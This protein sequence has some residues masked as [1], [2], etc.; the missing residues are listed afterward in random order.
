M[1]E[2]SPLIVPMTVEAFVVNDQVRGGTF[3]RAQMQYNPMILQ[4]TSAQPGIGD[5]DTNFTQPGT[6][7][8]NYY[9]GVY[10]KWRLPQFFT[11]GTQDNV[12]GQTNFP[13]VPNRWLVVRYSSQDLDSRSAAAWIVESDY[14]YPTALPAIGNASQIG[15]TYLQLQPG[16]TVPLTGVFIGRNVSLGSWTEPNTSLGLT[17]QGPGNNAFAFYQPQCNNVFSF[18]DPLQYDGIPA[19]QT[20]SYMVLGWFSSGADDPLSGATA[21][22]FAARVTNLGWSLPAGTDSSLYA[23]WS[24]LYGS[25]DNVQ[26]QTT[27]IGGGAPQGELPISIS[28]GNTSVEALT[29][30]ITVQA[31]GTLAIEPELLEAFQLDLLD[32]LDQPDGAAV[33]AE[34]LQAGFFQ[35]FSGGYTWTIVDAPGATSE[36]S[37]SELDVEATWLAAL[38]QAQQQLDAGLSQLVA[39]QA[40]LYVMWWK[41]TYWGQ[42]YLGEAAISG[43]ND[44]T[45]LQNQLDPTNPGSLAQRA[46]SQLKT[47]QTDRAAVPT[48]DTP[49]ALAAAIAAYAAAQKLPATRVLKRGAAPPF[50]LPNNPVVLIAGAGA[51]G[52]VQP[53]ASTLCRFPSQLVTG[54]QYDNGTATLSITASTVN[55]PQPDLSGVSGVPWPT[56][57]LTSLVDELFFL[58]QN[59]ATMVANAIGSTDIS[60]IASAMNAPANDLG[61]YPAGAFQWWTQNPWHPLLLIYETTY[62]PITYQTAGS[63]SSNWTFSEGQYTWNGSAASVGPALGP[64][65]VILLSATAALNMQARITAFLN[66]NP[67]LEPEETAELQALLHFVQTEDNWD[68]LSQSL[69]GFNDQL[70]LGMTGAFVSPGLTAPTT[71]PPLPT[72]LGFTGSY[73][74]G[75]GNIPTTSIPPSLFQPWRAGQFEF[76][77]LVVVDEWGQAIWPIDSNNAA[78][79]TV[80]LPPDLTAVIESAGATFT[81]AIG[82]IIGTLSPSL[83]AAGASSDFTLTVTGAGFDSAS[84]VNWNG[85][86]LTTTYVSANEL[87]TTVG[88]T[89]I[90]AAGT[91]SVTVTTGTETSAAS[92]FIIADGPAIQSLTPNLLQAGMAGTSLIPVTVTG[93]NFGS[94]AAVQWNGIAVVTDFVS[95][96]E[97]IGNVPVSYTAAPNTSQVTVF[98]GGVTSNAMT[99]TVCAGAAAGSLVPNVASAGGASFTI[100]LEGV[101]FSVASVVQWSTGGGAPAPLATTFVSDTQLTATVPAN[102]IA[103]PGSATVIES[104]GTPAVQTTATLIQLPPALLQPAQLDFELRSA[105]EDAV[106]FGPANP[107]A[108]PICGWVVPNHLDGSLLAFDAAGTALGEMSL[109]MPV[110]G[111]T[112]ICWFNAP[113]SPYASLANLAGPAGIPH[114]GP[115]LL[116]LSQKA[117]PTFTA[118]LN[119]IDETLW[120]TVPM[121]AVFDQSLAI[122]IGRPLAMVRASLQLML[123]GPPYA[124]PSWQYTFSTYTPVVTTYQFAIELGNVARLDDGL[125]GYFVKDTYTAFN[126]VQ[127]S[128]ATADGYL[129]PIGADGNYINLPPDNTTIEY[130]S[131]LVDPRAAVHATTGILPV[132]EVAL[133]PNLVDAALAAMNVTFR[134]DG[135][136]TD[137]QVAPGTGPSAT[138][139]LMPTPKGASGTWSW[140]ENDKQTWNTY[141]IAPVDATARLSDVAPVLRSGLLQLS[142]ALGGGTNDLRQNAGRIVNRRFGPRKR[143]NQ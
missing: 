1:S 132:A 53:P 9:N 16:S 104:V 8:S 136:L 41:Y 129:Q 128:G 113:G 46:S 24:L 25:V 109:G 70:R 21:A 45:G 61:T 88:T 39:L 7:W 38:N 48:G 83:A 11:Q 87:T 72:L 111:S 58:D 108:D 140:L 101:G 60:G 133:P 123:D 47:V 27:P 10:L 28:V 68:L 81:V 44:Q 99:F 79:E 64:Q 117:P 43:L 122:L 120:T 17:A 18:I 98:T 57:L 130:V 78:H 127:Q 96:T 95:S 102:L 14:V 35:R 29:A 137:E 2:Q 33:V 91:A 90:A 31:N 19:P 80:F 141:A 134:I 42:A 52:I 84:T 36:S 66:N 75:V 77:N 93:V 23:T 26:W 85:S 110:S 74:P 86:T 30:L 125:I 138:T 51:S 32:V 118:F 59:N 12:Q 89:Q 50:Y 54:F 103:S 76:V 97:V 15:S 5:N 40:Q 105:T 139:V 55:I 142:G 114:F 22:D 20:L 126:V 73:P 37:Q 69:D 34:K 71:N 49:D 56:S 143:R 63:S 119:A 82:P 112:T 100:T 135:L 124:D 107:A 116:A 67:N 6:N 115:F 92:T 13:L 106:V 94:D 3:A 131:M 62:Y 4:L 121:D 65:G